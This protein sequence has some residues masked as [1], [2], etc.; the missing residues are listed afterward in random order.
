[1]RWTGDYEKGKEF[2]EGYSTVDKFFLKI[3]DIVIRNKKPRRLE[4]Q[5]NLFMNLEGK[6]EYKVY[7]E[8]HEE[9]VRSC[10][11]GFRYFRC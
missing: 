11:G 4:L 10:V 8:S 2:F 3:R 6:A 7:E 1:M 9:I 5:V